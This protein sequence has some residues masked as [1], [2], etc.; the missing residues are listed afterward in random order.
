PAPR[1]LTYRPD[2]PNK[3]ATFS[4]DRLARMRS[5]DAGRF[6]TLLLSKQTPEGPHT[7]VLNKCRSVPLNRRSLSASAVT[8]SVPVWPPMAAARFLQLVARAAA[9]VS[10]PKGR[11]CPITGR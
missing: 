7:P 8:V 5:Y 6:I 2:F 9:S 4:P 11:E 10:R 1:E 3:P